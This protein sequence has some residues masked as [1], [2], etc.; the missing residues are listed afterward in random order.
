[1]ELVELV[2]AAL[3]DRR[4]FPGKCLEFILSSNLV[5][6]MSKVQIHHHFQNGINSRSRILY[7]LDHFI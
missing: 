7:L 4:F 5:L 6:I 1:M 3:Y 2:D